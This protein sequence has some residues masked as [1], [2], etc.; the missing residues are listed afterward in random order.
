[1]NT[2]LIL[3]NQFQSILTGS[4][5]IY[6]FLR[7]E[8]S[9]SDM[10]W[11]NESSIPLR[12]K[13]YR[14]GSLMTV[15]ILMKGILCMCHHM[16]KPIQPRQVH[17]H[18]GKWYSY[19]QVMWPKW[20]HE[21]HIYKPHLNRNSKIS[22][23]N[24]LEQWFSNQSSGPLQI[25]KIFL[26]HFIPHNTEQKCGLSENHWV[27]ERQKVKTSHTYTELM[28]WRKEAVD[29]HTMLAHA[30]SGVRGSGLTIV[31]VQQGHGAPPLPIRPSLGEHAREEDMFRGV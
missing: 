20:V 16:H 17:K 28:Q 15:T 31:R 10:K 13:F 25:V 21:Q 1:M 3:R 24:R 30:L 23:P 22:R 12:H 2:N 9:K 11:K 29:T 27:R 5:V 26:L 18:S 19:T 4:I 14:K 8:I 6:F 7:W